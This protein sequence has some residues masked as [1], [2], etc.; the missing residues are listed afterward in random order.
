MRSKRLVSSFLTLVLLAGSLTATLPANAAQAGQYSAPQW[1]PLRGSHLVGCGRNSGGRICEGNYHPVWA[2]D[3]EAN[4]GE[5]V[6]ASGAGWAWVGTDSTSC[7][8][9]GR[10]V[11]VSHNG[12][13]SLYAHLSAFSAELAAS[14]SGAWVDENTVIGYVGHTG[15]T[16]GCAFNH[17][18]YAESY[19][20]DFWSGAVDPGPFT[21]C[22]GS[23]LTTY[24]NSW[25]VE[26]W[27]GLPG[28][29][30]V[31][32]NDGSGCAASPTPGPTPST[33]PTL[34]STRANIVSWRNGDGSVTSWFVT[35][36]GERRWIPD[37]A[38]YWCLRGH[39]SADLGSQPSSTLDSLPDRGRWAWCPRDAVGHEMVLRRG[40]R[41]VSN[42]GRYRLEFQ[43][44]DGNLVIYGPSGRA[45]WAM[46][47]PNAEF[48]IMQPDGN[49]VQYP[50]SGPATWSTNTLGSGAGYVVMQSDGNL[51]VYRNNGVPVWWT[52]TTGRT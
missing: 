43:A 13:Y 17:L 9:Y 49:L 19:S 22:V 38:T 24:P 45:I 2:V 12:L 40:G 50:S 31:A 27:N 33:G 32:R 36:G 11:V 25:G 47:R 28:Q 8:N 52:G 26:S 37:A 18:H 20:M 30:F 29:T 23:Q 35:L 10:A 46:H 34:A 21:S 15:N 42:D 14:P 6:Y 5:P 51:V 1:L 41:L 16:S 4:E 39:G 48:L 44:S 3:F 7:E